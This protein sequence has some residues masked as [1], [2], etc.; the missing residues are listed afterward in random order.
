MDIIALITAFGLGSVVSALVQT[1]LSRRSKV[2]DRNFEERK[3][4]Y[5]GLLQAYHRAAVENSPD[6]GKEF[7]YWQMRCELVSP[8]SVRQAIE[9]IVETNDSREERIVAHDRLKAALRE[10]LGVTKTTP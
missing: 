8:A 1:Y 2:H 7:A 10:D 6:A 9:A 5:I 3:Q 4:A